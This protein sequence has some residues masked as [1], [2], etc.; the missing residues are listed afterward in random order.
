MDNIDK[1]IFIVGC[2]RSGTTLLQ[3]L[4]S[5]HPEIKSFPETNF[6][7]SA[8]GNRRKMLAR[9]GIA[10]GLE[11]K[12]LE[13]VVELLDQP[14][15]GSQIPHL[16]WKFSSAVGDFISILDGMTCQVGKKMWV[17]KTPLHVLYLNLIEK[18]VPGSHFVHIVRDGRDVVASI[19]D[20][21]QK[22]PEKFGNQKDPLMGIARW[23]Q[24]VRASLPYLGAVRHSFVRYQSLVQNTEAEMR[25]LASDL[26]IEYDQSMS[27]GTEKAAGDVILSKWPWISNARKRPQEKSSKFNRLCDKKEQMWIED[28]LDLSII[29]KIENFVHQYDS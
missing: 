28:K 17:E 23:N 22:Y 7:L 29:S 19:V 26:R 11:V 1:R 15:L 4:L 16:Y 5:S 24:A 8:A 14:E 20:R 18:Y 3:V 13:R 27:Q 10:T 12:A 25:R 21:A 9:I 6:F 2:S